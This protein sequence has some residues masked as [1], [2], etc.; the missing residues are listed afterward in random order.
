MKREISPRFLRYKLWHL[1]SEIIQEFCIK[2]N[3]GFIRC[4]PETVDAEGFLLPQFYADPMHV[5][6]AYGALVLTQ[7]RRVV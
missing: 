4:P 6:E 2:R 3:I 1:H 7:M 5:N